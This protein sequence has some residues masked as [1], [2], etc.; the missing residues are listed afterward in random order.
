M[1]KTQ[2]KLFKLSQRYF[3]YEYDEGT[4]IQRG[5]ATKKLF[6]YLAKAERKGL[7]NY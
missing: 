3:D 7:T 2:L 4:I 1:T 6:K 5:R